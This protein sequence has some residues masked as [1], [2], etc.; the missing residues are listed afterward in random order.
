MFNCSIGWQ[1][2]KVI[3]TSPPKLVSG[4]APN[5]NLLA[6]PKFLLTGDRFL[7]GILRPVVYPQ[8]GTKFGINNYQRFFKERKK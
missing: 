1:L 5:R 3:S 4:G 8:D 6:R 7:R 2:K